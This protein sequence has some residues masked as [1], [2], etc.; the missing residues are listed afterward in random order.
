MAPGAIWRFA[1]YYGLTWC[2]W[3]GREY[4]RRA[5]QGSFICVWVI[6]NN[7]NRKDQAVKKEGQ[8]MPPRWHVT[9]L[10]SWWRI[11]TSLTMIILHQ[12]TVWPKYV[13]YS[14]RST[15]SSS[16]IF[17]VSRICQS[18]TQW[19]HIM[20]DTAQSSTSVGSQSTLVIR[21]GQ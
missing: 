20:A 18:M 21:F 15:L 14:Q 16:P 3:S 10:K 9:A 1:F 6:D 5:R 13:P 7:T 2:A 12:M 11:F 4:K 19:C 8:A 17:H